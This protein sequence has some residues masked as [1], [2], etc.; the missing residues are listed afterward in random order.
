MGISE[1]RKREKGRRRQHILVASR[2]LIVEKGYGNATMDAIAK[3]AELSPGTVYLYFKTKEE[4]LSSLSVRILQYFLIRIKHISEEA[5]TTPEK[6]LESLKSALLDAYSFDSSIVISLLRLQS[7]E[8]LHHLSNEL[9][10][11]ILDLA[12]EILGK[13]VEVLK[14]SL[15]KDVF[16]NQA[17]IVLA[18]ILWSMFSGVVLRECFKKVAGDNDDSIR[19]NFEL[20]FEIFIR[21]LQTQQKLCINNNADD[22]DFVRLSVD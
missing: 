19:T 8:T 22:V 9:L 1:R 6:Q 20:A 12:R 13:I 18:D 14:N 16:K 15:D 3:E 7:S 2:R 4:L 10:S 17:P 11:E 5:H 21:G